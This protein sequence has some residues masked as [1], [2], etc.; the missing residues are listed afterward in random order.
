MKR[1]TCFTAILIMMAAITTGS[2]LA[3]SPAAERREVDAS[4]D[5]NILMPSAETLKQNEFAFNSYELFWAG[6]SWGAL[7]TLQLSFTTMIPAF[8]DIPIGG[9]L[10]AK[11]KII[12]TDYALF[13]VQPGGIFLYN[14]GESGGGFQIGLLADFVLPTKTVFSLSNIHMTSVGGYD[15][16]STWLMLTT[17]GVNQQLGS[18]VKLMVEFTMPSAYNDGEFFIEDKLFFISYG[19][20]FFWKK[21][22]FDISFIRPL[23]SEVNDILLMGYP[24]VTF[25]VRF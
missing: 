13:S 10:T 16:F 7:D 11:W 5:R 24:Y 22:A 14:D 4:V 9:M 15:D 12:D 2:L 19:V 20:R 18:L 21:I 23:A 1:S 17:I 6:F 25:T 3:A 8:A